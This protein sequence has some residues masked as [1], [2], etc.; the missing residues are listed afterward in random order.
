MRGYSYLFSQLVRR[1][2]RQKYKGSAL[3]VL[4]Y[5]VNPLVLM[6][7]YGVMLG[8]VLKA[9]NYSDYPLFILAGLL[10]WLFFAQ[11]LTGAAT[12]LVD[13]SALISKVRF[14]RESIP[15]ASVAVQLVPY[16]AMLVVLLPVTLV[17]RGNPSWALL[18]LIP[19]TVCL[20]AFTLGLSLIGA[21]AHAY[22]RDVQ[23][24]LTATLLPWFFISGVL[25]NLQSLPGLTAH[26]WIEPLLRWVNPV[27]PFIEATRDIIYGGHVPAGATLAYVVAAAVLS[28]T[29]GAAVFHRGE[30]ELAV[31]L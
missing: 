31:V 22:Y 23:P 28:L 16:L 3:G 17:I 14:P 18:L 21:T 5:L 12:S 7:V 30:G 15:A 29:A 9:V 6:A 24:I 27:A 20:F 4:W 25:F 26:H 11:A 2:L 1:E 8:P 10:V 13:Q 19:L